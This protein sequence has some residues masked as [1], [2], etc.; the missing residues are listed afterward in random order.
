MPGSYGPDN[1][2]VEAQVSGNRVTLTQ[3]RDAAGL[4]KQI[5]VTLAETGT[6]VTIAHRLTNAHAVARSI[7]PPGR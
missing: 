2:P 3:P 7:S 4:E 6:G 1:G 5:T